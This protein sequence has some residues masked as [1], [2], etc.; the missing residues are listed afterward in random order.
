[1]NYIIKTGL[2]ASSSGQ[3]TDK[4]VIDE[5][6][7]YIGNYTGRIFSE[8]PIN[9]GK[10]VYKNGD[11]YEGNWFN[12]RAGQGSF[13]SSVDGLQYNLV[14]QWENDEPVGKVTINFE[15]GAKYEGEVRSWK[16]NGKGILTRPDGT[17]WEG[18]FKDDNPVGEGTERDIKGKIICSCKFDWEPPKSDVELKTKA[19]K[20]KTIDSE[21]NVFKGT[22]GVFTDPRD[23]QSYKWIKIGNQIWMAQNLNAVVFKNGIKLMEAK[24]SKKW[25]SSGK[26]NLSS[27]CTYDNN[28]GLEPGYGKLYN[29]YAIEDPNDLAPEGWHIP[30]DEDWNML[31]NFLGGEGKAGIKMK[32]NKSW[33]YGGN[34]TNNSGFAALPGGWRGDIEQVS[35]TFA[36]FGTVG[37]FWSASPYNGND[38]DFAYMLRSDLSK[39]D[40]LYYDSKWIGFS[41]RCLKD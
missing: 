4:K 38:D 2:F 27:Y 7:V 13:N 39:I 10:L 1:M 22:N 28:S 24:T 26:D 21:V 6:G 30:T 16:Y 35:N 14:G 18:K 33:N 3:V 11:I 15:N 25:I 5:N 12:V 23:N 40:K 36:E 31:I 32:S 8:R 29:R 19:K 41:V 34:G 37:V 20:G 9:Q 17:S